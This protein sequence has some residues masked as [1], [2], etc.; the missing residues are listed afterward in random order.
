LIHWING[1]R[2]KDWEEFTKRTK[3]YEGNLTHFLPEVGLVGLYA[4]QKELF[5]KS[6][7]AFSSSGISPYLIIS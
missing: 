4:V 6:Y 1:K 2:E 3:K 7:Y 5:S